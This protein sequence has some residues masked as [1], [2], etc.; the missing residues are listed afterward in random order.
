[1]IVV[2]ECV[3]ART[4]RNMEAT[5]E[6]VLLVGLSAILPNYKQNDF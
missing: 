3:V 5:Q 1:M 4:L 2:L 6:D